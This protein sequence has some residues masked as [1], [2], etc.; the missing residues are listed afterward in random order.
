MRREFTTGR[1][2]MLFLFSFYCCL[3]KNQN[4]FPKG[5]SNLWPQFVLPSSNWDIPTDEH[6]R[7]ICIHA[8]YRAIHKYRFTDILQMLYVSFAIFSYINFHMLSLIHIVQY[9][10]V[11]LQRFPFVRILRTISFTF[12]R[13]TFFF[14]SV[15]PFFAFLFSVSNSSLHQF[16]QY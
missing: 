15:F 8:W 3:C 16:Y 9:C 4:P 2:Y 12:V 5:A 13:L 11:Y 7:N 1:Q 14:G 10:L 6:I